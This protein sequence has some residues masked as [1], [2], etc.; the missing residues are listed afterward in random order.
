MKNIKSLTIEMKTRMTVGFLSII[1]IISFVNSLNVLE[2]SLPLFIFYIILMINTYFSL[3]LFLAII[4]T[5]IFEQKMMDVLLIISYIL[6]AFSFKYALLFSY[7]L[8]LFFILA[9]LKYALFVKHNEKHPRLLRRKIVVNILGTLLSLLTLG[10]ILLGYETYSLWFLPIVFLFA[11]IVIF[12]I[13][14]LYKLDTHY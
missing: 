1:G 6:L 10:G 14:P 11:N 8:T 13:S 4:P 3:K 2:V 9:T 12:F 5:H 7:L